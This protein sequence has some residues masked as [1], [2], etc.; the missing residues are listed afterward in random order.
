MKIP[1]DTLHITT[2]NTY[3]VVNYAKVVVNLDR[4]LSGT[5]EI[6]GRKINSTGTAVYSA[7]MN[8]SI[9]F[10]DGEGIHSGTNL[11]FN[12]SGMIDSKFEPAGERTLYSLY[13]REWKYDYSI[14]DYPIAELQI[15]GSYKVSEEFY[16]QFIKVATCISDGSSSGGSLS[17]CTLNTGSY[18]TSGHLFYTDADGATQYMSINSGT[19]Q[20]TIT[21]GKIYVIGPESKL[22]LMSDTQSGTKLD[23]LDS[24]YCIEIDVPASKYAGKQ[25][26]FKYAFS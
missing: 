21:C 24:N 8:Y 23:I 5:W 18:P 11:T 1:T 6:D 10:G 25:V 19:G 14:N 13:E 9:Q 15:D 22:G 2:N 3:D 20:I 17:T 16:Q 12:N 4:T 7:D 26:D